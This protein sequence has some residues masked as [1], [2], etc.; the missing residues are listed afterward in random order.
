MEEWSWD[1]FILGFV[2]QKAILCF[3]LSRWEGLIVD[4]RIPRDVILRPNGLKVSRVNS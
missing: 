4:S 2:I 1:Q 3:F